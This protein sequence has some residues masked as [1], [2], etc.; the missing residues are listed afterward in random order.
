MRNKQ[1][2]LLILAL[3]K[4]NKIFAVPISHIFNLSLDSGVFPKKMKIAI[5]IP[6]Y[7]KNDSLDCNNYRAISLLLISV[8]YLKNSSKIDFQSS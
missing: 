6:V 5:V 2:D 8:K 4:F 7:K 3:A 1:R